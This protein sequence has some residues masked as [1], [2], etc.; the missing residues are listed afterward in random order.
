MRTNTSHSSL[1]I[2]LPSPF[3]VDGVQGTF[4]SQCSHAHTEPGEA[5][6]WRV[7]LSAQHVIQAVII[8]N[9]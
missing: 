2:S 3:S 5:A 1:N 6:W 4:L 9:G 7:D 8:Y